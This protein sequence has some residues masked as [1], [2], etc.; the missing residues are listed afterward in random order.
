MILFLFLRVLTFE[1]LHRELIFTAHHSNRSGWKLSSQEAD[2][3]AGW[4]VCFKQNMKQQK[5][6]KN[7]I[8]HNNTSLNKFYKRYIDFYDF[9]KALVD[10][11]GHNS[12]EPSP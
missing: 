8:L 4:F 7:W 10:P 5:S 1:V 12:S 6:V 11:V 9:R 2:L 3:D